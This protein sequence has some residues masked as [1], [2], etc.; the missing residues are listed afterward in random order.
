MGWGITVNSS[1]NIYITGTTEGVLDGNTN[2]GDDDLFLVKYN[3]SG[4]KQWIKQFGTPFKDHVRGVMVD[5][6]NNIYLTG[7]TN[8]ELGG[9][10]NYGRFDVI[11]FKFSPDG[12]RL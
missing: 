6:M 1:D 7:F 8:G 10:I 2:L 12:E 11:L 5:S 3:S 9:K 4:T